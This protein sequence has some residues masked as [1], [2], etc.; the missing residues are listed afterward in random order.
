MSKVHKT[1]SR[2]NGKHDKC[3]KEIVEYRITF[4][5]SVSSM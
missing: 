3:T 4:S 1:L 2:N 5:T